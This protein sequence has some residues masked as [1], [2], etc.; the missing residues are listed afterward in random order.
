M[1]EL[2]PGFVPALEAQNGRAVEIDTADS[3]ADAYAF[4]P[5]GAGPWPA[6]LF[7]MDGPG[8]RPALFEMARRLAD[9]GYFVL[10]P[11]LFYRAGAYQPFDPATV[12]SN[13]D[14][15]NRLMQLI[16]SVTQDQ[17]RRDTA[18]FI[19]FLDQ[20][21]QAEG[22]HLGTVGYC[23]GGSLALAT[24]GHFP[25][26]VAAAAAFHAA[27]LATDQPDSPHL[28]T[29]AIRAKLYIGVAGIDQSFSEAERH[30]LQGALEAGG[31]DFRLEVYPDARHGFAVNDMPVY[32]R[33]ASERHWQRLLDLFATT[34]KSG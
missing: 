20:Q 5:E 3:G 29:S 24:A 32:D 9:Q 19:T 12:F 1:P 23:M 6:V 2:H 8:I 34:L 21:P 7:Y 16:H 26:R 30:R 28:L 27:R 18:D 31:V 4:S 13:A 10:L 11:N 25:D 33:E 17:A 22:L 15:R 14:E